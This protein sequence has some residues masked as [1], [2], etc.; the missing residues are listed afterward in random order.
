MNPWEILAWV[1]ALSLATVVAAIA[2]A[3]I[4]GAAKSMVA[5]RQLAERSTQVMG[6]DR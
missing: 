5:P 1:G 2:L 4:V 6:G 3:V